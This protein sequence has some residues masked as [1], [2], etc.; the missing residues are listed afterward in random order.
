MGSAAGEWFALRGQVLE[1]FEG[2]EASES[3][4]GRNRAGGKGVETD[5]ARPRFERK[6]SHQVEHAGLRHRRGHNISRS[7]FGVGGGN[8]ENASMMALFEP[9]PATGQSDVKRSHQHDA[10][11]CFKSPKGEL[12][13][14]RNEVAGS[15]VDKNIERTVIPDL[16]NHGFNASAIT[17]VTNKRLDRAPGCPAKFLG[18]LVQHLLAT[19]ADVEGGPKF[20]AALAH[21]FAQPGCASG[22]EDS[23]AGQ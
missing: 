15:V 7:T 22:N 16:V 13:R 2:H 1:C 23:F 3:V 19:S 6:T 8:A 11:H 18:G 12:L 21:A 5:A 17:H 10:D 9:P 4:L 14:P 20:K